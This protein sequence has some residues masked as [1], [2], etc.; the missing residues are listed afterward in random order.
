M[1]QYAQTTSYAHLL[2]DKDVSVETYDPFWLEN[3]ERTTNNYKTDIVLPGI[4]VSFLEYENQESFKKDEN[5][6]FKEKWPEVD[7]TLSKMKSIK[8]DLL[9]VADAKQLPIIV[10]CYSYCYFETLAFS[11]YINKANLHV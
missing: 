10:L 7:I 2:E 5:D 8:R 4:I 1:S 6:Q 11:K 9:K 3:P